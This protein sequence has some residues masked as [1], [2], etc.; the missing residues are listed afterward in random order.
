M[1]FD[2]VLFGFPL[3]LGV[4]L[5]I[6][7]YREQQTRFF[8]PSCCV[9]AYCAFYMFGGRTVLLYLTCLLMMGG[10]WAGVEAGISP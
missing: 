5:A 10:A 6:I 8:R 7:G 2:V 9:L 4:C 1:L 3:V